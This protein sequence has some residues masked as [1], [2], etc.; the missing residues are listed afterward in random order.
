MTTKK[1]AA[2]SAVKT[3]KE[4]ATKP[5]AAPVSAPA[6][7][8][9]IVAQGEADRLKEFNQVMSLKRLEMATIVEQVFAAVE[10]IGMIRNNRAEYVKNLADKY[11][12]G[13]RQW[14]IDGQTLEIVFTD[15]Q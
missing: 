7:D 12:V 2:K 10:Q 9:L 13:N 15:N 1:P 14:S 8:K 5:A 11:N 6:P 3:L 4:K